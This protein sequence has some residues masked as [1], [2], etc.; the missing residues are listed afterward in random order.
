ML[1]RKAMNYLIKWKENPDH[2]FRREVSIQ[3]R[4]APGREDGGQD[5]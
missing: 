2:P 3:G 4:N 1:K 5:G